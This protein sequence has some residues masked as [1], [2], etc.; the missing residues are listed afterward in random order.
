MQK[1]EVSRIFNAP[2]ELVWKVWEDPELVKRWWGP[3][4]FTSPTAIRD[5]RVGGESIVSM[6]APIELG[7]Q[8]YFSLWLYSKIDYI[9][10]IEFNQSLCDENGKKINPE[11]VGMPSDFPFDIKTIVTFRAITE[12]QTKMTVTEFAKFGSISNFAQIG[13]EQ[14]IEKMIDIFM[15]K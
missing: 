2:I 8:I 6:Q 1:I 12:T 3:K 15:K 4:T 5:F 9:Q 13:L 10:L 11:S 14:S 7:G